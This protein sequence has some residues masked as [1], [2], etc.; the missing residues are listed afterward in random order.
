[1][2]DVRNLSTPDTF[3]Q[4]AFL[5]AAPETLPKASDVTLQGFLSDIVYRAACFLVK[6]L[7]LHGEEVTELNTGGDSNDGSPVWTW[8]RRAAE[9]TT[10]IIGAYQLV[11]YVLSK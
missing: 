7:P 9:M 8:L 5:S 10:V 11:E 4:P 3:Q 1:M 6:L 2:P